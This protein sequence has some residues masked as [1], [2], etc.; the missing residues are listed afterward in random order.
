MRHSGLTC[1]SGTFFLEPLNGV[2]LTRRLAPVHCQVQ[3]T[4]DASGCVGCEAVCRP[5]WLQLKWFEFPCSVAPLRN[6][7]S[8][9][10]RELMLIVL[11]CA[12]WGP[13]WSGRPG[14]SA[15]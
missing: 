9:T 12:V 3:F 13:G 8:I 2:S 1:V 14:S 15:L 6:E 5:W 11:A 4:T 7:D 10:L